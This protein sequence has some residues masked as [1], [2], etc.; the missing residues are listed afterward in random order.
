MKFSVIILLLMSSISAVA[1]DRRTSISERALTIAKKIKNLDQEI[2]RRDRKEISFY[3]TE[4]EEVLRFYNANPGRVTRKL[5]CDYSGGN[6]LVDLANGK[7][8]YDFSSAND[9]T[10]AMKKIEKNLNFCDYQG[11]NLLGN[12]QGQII[13]DFSS[14]SD[15]IEGMKRV[16]KNLNFCD[17]QGGNLLNDSQ[18]KLIY[19]FSSANECANALE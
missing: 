18:G 19:D 2:N 4:L 12:S 8:I 5:T 13:Y 3:L 17:Y 16:D 1:Q 9:C 11:G 14:V 10:E 7:L 6:L 15:C